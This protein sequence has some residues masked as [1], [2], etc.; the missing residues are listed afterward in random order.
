MRS[1]P[2]FLL[3]ALPLAASADIYKW[4]DADGHVHFSDRADKGRQQVEAVTPGPGNHYTPG[5]DDQD[6][7]EKQRRLIDVMQ[8]EAAER[9]AAERKLAEQ[10]ARKA[11][12][13]EQQRDT[14]RKIDGI[15]AYY[16]NDN[17]EREFLD[18]AAR[19]KYIGQVNAWLK[20]NC[21]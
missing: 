12:Q 2:A 9:D 20:E 4:T 6:R 16:V 1:H 13:C 21:D 19:Q 17:G 8:T 15:P 3:L 10:K 5:G 14:L 11:R 18:D 7:L